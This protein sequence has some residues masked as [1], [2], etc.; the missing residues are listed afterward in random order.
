MAAKGR[1]W[2]EENLVEGED[3]GQGDTNSFGHC[4]LI[5]PSHLRSA[6]PFMSPVYCCLSR[7]SPLQIAKTVG[8]AV[9]AGTPSGPSASAREA[10]S[11]TSP[12][13][14]LPLNTLRRG[15]E[16]ELRERGEMKGSEG[17][18]GFSQD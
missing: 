7:R 17:I 6:S 9:P 8:R 4:P 12:S 5:S 11:R 15:E 18:E 2:G 16:G 3:V 1:E 10:G 14:A 13:A